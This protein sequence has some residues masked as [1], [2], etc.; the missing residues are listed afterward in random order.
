MPRDTA[1]AD[2][3]L[4]EV[5]HGLTRDEEA[6][7]QLRAIGGVIEWEFPDNAGQV[8]RLAV[9]PERGD[10]LVGGHH[11]DAVVTIS[12]PERIV[13]EFMLG[14]VDVAVALI[15]GE[16]VVKGS[17]EAALALLS[18]LPLIASAYRAYM[19]EDAKRPSHQVPPDLRAVAARVDGLAPDVVGDIPDQALLTAIAVAAQ[20]PAQRSVAAARLFNGLT[21]GTIDVS[22]LASYTRHL[23]DLAAGNSNHHQNR[24]QQADAPVEDREA[25]GLPL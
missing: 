16:V 18:V 24:Q 7:G 23:A 8:R 25:A 11:A 5:F 14:Q 20:E 21:R 22:R 4:K 10:I 3:F 2:E 12:I 19:E 13:P 15:Q 9:D 6:R 1:H 17:R